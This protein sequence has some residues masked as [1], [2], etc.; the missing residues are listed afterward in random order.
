MLLVLTLL[1][2]GAEP[3][4]VHDFQAQHP[5]QPVHNALV[6]ASGKLVVIDKLLPKLK[7]NGHKVRVPNVCQSLMQ[8]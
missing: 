8:Y 1:P 3:K 4:I 6:Q 5:E 2:A 7:E